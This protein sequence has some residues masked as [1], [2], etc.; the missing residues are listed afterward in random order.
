M[1][2]GLGTIILVVVLMGV[3]APIL[4]SPLA[5]LWTAAVPLRLDAGRFTPREAAG[6]ERPSGRSRDRR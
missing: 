6:R 2:I 3:L 1:Q 4:V 5:R